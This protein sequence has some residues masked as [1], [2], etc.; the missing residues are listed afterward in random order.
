M[1]KLATG[2]VRVIDMLVELGMVRKTQIPAFV[3][4]SWVPVII[5]SL[6]WRPDLTDRHL[7]KI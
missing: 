6:S 5:Y 7:V 3:Y 2:S 4:S 1:V